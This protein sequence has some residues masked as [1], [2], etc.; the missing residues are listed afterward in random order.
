MFVIQGR[1]ADACC[2]T[3]EIEEE[4]REDI[5]GLC[6]F[7]PMRGR[8]ICIMPDVHPNGDGS[9]TGFTMTLREPVIL[10]LEYGSGCG[11][12]A[13]RLETDPV[14]LKKLDEACYALPDGGGKRPG[15]PAY[16]YDFSQLRCYEELRR[17]YENPVSLG[18]LGGGNHFIEMDR[19]EEGSLYLI[20]HNGLGALARPVLRHYLLRAIRT[21]GNVSLVNGRPAG[22]VR[23]EDTCLYGKDME[24]YLHD[25]KI[26]EDVCRK[27]RRWLAEFITD[28][29][30]IRAAEYTDICHH[31]TDET[32]SVVRHGAI[33][34]HE[35]ERVL[36][37]I[38]AREGCILGTGRGNPDW[39]YSAPHGAGRLLSRRAARREISMEDYIG[40]MQDVY[41]TTVCEEN[42][43][44]AP[45]AYKT[46]ADIAAQILD[47]VSID[48]I[49]RPVYNYKGK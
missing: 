31:Y 30:G 16:D 24:D 18:C 27:N 43:D 15:K 23:F 1:V 36:I 32:D 28:R 7:E 42:L 3:V 44:E 20:V 14:D 12:L 5:A 41:S 49:L 17:I 35:G 10:A 33:S 25:M 34:A 8:R 39:N 6:D 22:P 48:R 38:N 29:A 9:V 4:A 46:M 11:V 40:A 45:A 19:D 47:T 2:F 37:P 13:A 26:M 21:S